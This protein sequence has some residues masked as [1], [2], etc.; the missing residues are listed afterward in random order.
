[1]SR[2]GGWRGPVVRCVEA[3]EGVLGCSRKRDYGTD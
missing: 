1:M 3:R 2:S